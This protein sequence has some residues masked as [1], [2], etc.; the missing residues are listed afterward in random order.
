MDPMAGQRD[1]IMDNITV[2][3]IEDNA[4][5][6]ILFKDLLEA[7][8]YTVLE[9][10]NAEDGIQKARDHSP[11]LVLMDIQLPGMDGLAATRIF[12]ADADLL[13]IPVVALTS[14][15]MQGDEEKAL[16]AGCQGYIT[17]PINTR[18]FLDTIA[19]FLPN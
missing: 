14:Y 11:H 8:G 6:K 2:L 9:A 16:A 17:K 3:I 18:N 12:K 13:K 1:V 15:A 7:H 5:N 10:E 4:L 19:Q